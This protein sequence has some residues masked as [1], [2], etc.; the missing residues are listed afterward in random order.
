MQIRGSSFVTDDV[1]DRLTSRSN[2]NRLLVRAFADALHF[3]NELLSQ[4][5]VPRQESSE[6]KQRVIALFMLVRLVEIAES[7]FILAAHGVR[8]D[9]HSLFRIFLDAYFLIANVC[10]DPGFVPV[11]FRTDE[12]A[13]LKLMKAGSRRDDAL[14]KQLNDYATAELR[15]E[16]DQKIKQERI[17]AYNSYVFAQRAKC[18]NIY[19]SMYRLCSASVH[20]TPR[21]LGQ[22]VEV[23][24]EGSIRALIHAGDNET[25]HRVLYDTQYFLMKVL[26]GVCEIFDFPDDG[27]LSSLDHAR[28]SAMENAEP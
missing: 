3:S 2:I 21:C 20:S 15:N 18:E 23:D 1:V 24:D 28:E 11:Y 25:I 26:R 22:Y 12:P 9:L 14:F 6:E 16:L 5:T 27:K 8:E 10:S 4:L 19:D 17:E 13:R 7:T